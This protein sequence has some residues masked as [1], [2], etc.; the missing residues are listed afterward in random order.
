[1][2]ELAAPKSPSIF[3]RQM[4]RDASWGAIAIVIFGVSFGAWA[5]LAPLHSAVVAGGSVR[6]VGSAKSVQH[7]TGGTVRSILVR[8]GDRVEGGQPLV[9]LDTTIAKASLGITQSR[10]DQLTV[11]A[12]RLRAER[13]GLAKL[14]VPETLLARQME[15]DIATLLAS[16]QRVL[17]LRI[18]T[19]NGSKEQLEAQVKQIEAS[20]AGNE[21]QISA[22]TAEL[23][24]LRSERDTVKTLFNDGL[25]SQSRLN[26]LE[27][28]AL[29]TTGDVGSLISSIAQSRQLMAE[30]E[31]QIL[32]IDQRAASE[33]SALLQDTETSVAEYS[34]RVLAGKDQLERLT[35]RAPASGVISRM[36]IFTLGGVIG[37]GETIMA[38]VPEGGELDI[39][40]RVAAPD[41]DSVSVGNAVRVRLSGMNSVSTP[42]L[43]GT[44]TRVAP[45]IVSDEQLGIAYYPVRLTLDT[46]EDARLGRA[47]VPGMP[48]EIFI[49]GETRTFLQYLWKPIDDRLS[50][51]MLEE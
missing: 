33:A 19:R 6:I 9:Q 37:A 48:V 44:V 18:A 26:E 43:H 16:E 29:Q 49:S 3:T 36:E 21:Q 41:I 38:I 5:A 4:S 11:L 15:P 22:R 47:L 46:G 45:D 35:I 17:D 39:E 14:A 32:G 51:A 13:D 7:E 2:A 1:M 31:I 34:E 42:E 23:E 20:I 12:A 8:E 24:F 50:R 25:A 28:A 40:A 27:R 30:L 10:L